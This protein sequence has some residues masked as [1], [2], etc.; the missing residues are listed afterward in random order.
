MTAHD[1]RDEIVLSWQELLDLACGFLTA[2]GLSDAQA[3][4]LAGALCKAERDGCR[5][6]G[7]RRLPGTVE[8]MA[9]PAFDREADPVPRALTPATQFVREFT[10]A[11]DSR[12]LAVQITE[13]GDADADQ[14][15]RRIFWVSTDGGAPQLFAQTEGK[16]GPM[17]WSPDGTRLA[18]LG[19]IR[20]NDPLAQSIF[21]AAPGGTPT[22]LTPNYEGTVEWIGWQDARTI[23]FTAVEST[24]TVLG[25][26]P[27]AGGARTMIVG[28]GA[29]I[30]RSAS[31]SRDG[32]TFAMPASTAEVTCS[33]V[34]F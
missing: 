15:D 20:M 3:A 30:F 17:A 19:A 10:W 5:S 14:M 22:N 6:H 21:V 34:A 23:R 7:L 4:A 2:H 25:T 9:H 26:V 18:W 32:A 29:H 31:F 24:R 1:E 8:T 11:P 16:L 28:P 27:A 33:P 13:E 12:R